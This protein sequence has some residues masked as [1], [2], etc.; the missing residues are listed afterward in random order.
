MTFTNRPKDSSNEMEHTLASKAIHNTSTLPPQRPET[1]EPA[2]IGFTP[3]TEVRTSDYSFSIYVD[4][5]GIR[6]QDISITS[7]ATSI[8]IQGQRKPPHTNN[9]V[10]DSNLSIGCFERI[11]QLPQPILGKQVYAEYSQGVLRLELPK[12][13]STDSSDELSTTCQSMRL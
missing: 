3:P 2:S 10:I 1:T 5:P 4:L 9:P 12:Q 13:L 8:T 7:C 11:I 6:A